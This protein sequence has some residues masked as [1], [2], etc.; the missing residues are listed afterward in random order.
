MP[1]AVTERRLV[2]LML[3]LFL[4]TFGD[5]GILWGFSVSLFEIEDLIATETGVLAY[6][7]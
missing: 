7:Y 2:V 1:A 6:P 3:L 5:L 4:L